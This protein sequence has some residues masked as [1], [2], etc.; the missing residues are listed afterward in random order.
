MVRGYLLD[1]NIVSFWFDKSKPEHDRVIKNIA[2]LS[3]DSP[4]T[5]S[6]VTLGEIEYGHRAQSAQETPI[7][8]EYKDFVQKQLPIVLEIRKTTTVHYG[9]L[10]ARLFEKYL[11]NGKKGLRPE[12]LRD[13]VTSLR[14]GIHENDLWIAAQAV[15]HNLILVTHDNVDHLRAIGSNDLVLEDWAA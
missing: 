11:R 2:S 9:M 12:Q 1:T 4:L 5:I 10:R 6:V 15:E 3:A 14:L 7:Q 13:P 8:T